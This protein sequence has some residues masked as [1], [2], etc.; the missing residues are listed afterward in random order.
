MGDTDDHDLGRRLRDGRP[1]A[2][3]ELVRRVA[4]GT[5]ARHDAR[6]RPRLALAFALSG[7]LLVSLVAFG[8]VG[9]AS[10]VVHSSTAALRSAVGE[11][12]ATTKNHNSP[13]K[14]QYHRKVYICFPVVKWVKHV[15]IVGKHKRTHRVK[16]ITY[17]TKLV[18]ASSVP[19]LVARGSIYPVPQG[20]CSSGKTPPVS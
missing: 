2:S 7:A 13:W 4:E 1:E 20:G 3:E 14:K 9:A 11:R 8:G 5:R 19:A 12:A 15:K 18:S 10:G 6:P 16:V 17:V